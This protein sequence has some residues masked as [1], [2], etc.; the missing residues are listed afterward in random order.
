LAGDLPD[1][2]APAAVA[3]RTGDARILVVEDEPEVRQ[4]LVDLLRDQGYTV[5]ETGNG[6]DGLSLCEVTP[7]DL[8]ITDISMPQLSG[9]GVVEA[10]QQRFKVPVGIITGWGDTLDPGLLERYAIR[11]V[12][13]KPFTLGEVLDKVAAAVPK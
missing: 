5:D 7:F 2:K 13:A 3:R 8:V 10:C 12:L 1:I 9:W 11:F 6:A 4:V